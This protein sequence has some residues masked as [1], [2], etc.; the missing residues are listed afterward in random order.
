MR[1]GFFYLY[2]FFSF[3]ILAVNF[4]IALNLFGLCDLR[5]RGLGAVTCGVAVRQIAI[6]GT[7]IR[8]NRE[9]GA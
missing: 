1:Q 5:L 3:D 7:P 4:S 8:S 2:L 9:G 6:S